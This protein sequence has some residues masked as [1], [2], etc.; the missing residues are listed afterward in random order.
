MLAGMMEALSRFISK[1]GER[2]V[3]FY[4]P[5]KADGF[6]WDEQATIALTELKQYLKSLATL[7]PLK[8]NDV[9]LLYVSTIDAVISTVITVEWYDTQT[10]AK[11][12]GY[13][14]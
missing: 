6:W 13:Q 10:E 4:K 2:D 14:L 5:G 1:S 9:L 7:V 8:S 11:Q 12:Q 3:P